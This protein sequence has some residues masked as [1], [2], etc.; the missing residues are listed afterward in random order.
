MVIRIRV[1]SRDKLNR[2]LNYKV[3]R[4]QPKKGSQMGTGS[5]AEVVVLQLRK[6]RSPQRR[7]K[8]QDTRGPAVAIAPG[9]RVGNL[10][11]LT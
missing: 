11:P 5:Q 8:A 2:V 10:C 7:G 6:L 4:F 3:L 9:N 1:K